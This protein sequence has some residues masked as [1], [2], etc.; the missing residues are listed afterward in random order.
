MAIAALST[1]PDET[2]QLL[3]RIIGCA[4]QV[5]RQLGPGFLERI[6]TEALCIELEIQ[7]LRFERE[8]AVAV[9]DRDRKIVGQ[10]IDLIVEG[11]VI[12]EVKS[13]AR[14]DPIFQ[15]KMISY[16]RTTGFRA[17]LLVNFNAGLLKEGLKRVVL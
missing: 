9:A 3:E 6:Y 8:R 4:L 11:A 7:G 14:F 12:V 15:A 13:V 2:E 1:L 10:R 16:L 5:H 17:G